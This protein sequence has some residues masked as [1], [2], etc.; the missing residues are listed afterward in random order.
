LR[1][2]LWFYSSHA[3]KASSLCLGEILRYQV[4][5]FPLAAWVRVAFCA[6]RLGPFL[7]VGLRYCAIASRL[8]LV[9]V[10][11]S[12]PERFHRKFR[13]P[14]IEEVGSKALPCARRVSVMWLESWSRLYLQRGTP[15]GQAF[16]R[17]CTLDPSE[18]TVSTLGRVESRKWMNA[19]SPVPEEADST[20]WMRVVDGV[21]R[22]SDLSLRLNI[23]LVKEPGWRR[24]AWGFIKC[25]RVDLFTRGQRGPVAAGILWVFFSL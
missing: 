3:K 5:F 6:I 13:K 18:F 25:M 15:S 19:F 11:W 23:C 9:L 16:T 4:C 1:L 20:L 7:S 12:R 24:A 22:L 8:S 14:F 21:C 2:L 10:L 17:I